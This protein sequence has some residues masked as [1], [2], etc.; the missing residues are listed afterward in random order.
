VAHGREVDS[1]EPFQFGHILIGVL[2]LNRSTRNAAAKRENS[3]RKW[4]NIEPLCGMSFID[5][6]SGSGLFS[7]A[8]RRLGFYSFE[9]DPY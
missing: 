5:I 6:G 9:C 4:L 8:A 7:L 2:N 3:S 1:G